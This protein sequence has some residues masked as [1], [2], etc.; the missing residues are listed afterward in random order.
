VARAMQRVLTMQDGR[1]H[2][3]HRIADPLT[4]D[5]RELARSYLGQRLVRGDVASLRG[6]PLVEGN[7]LSPAGQRLAEVLR[8]L[9]AVSSGA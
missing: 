2:S 4:E 3:D 1:I 6:L 9:S 5:L 8:G 7:Q